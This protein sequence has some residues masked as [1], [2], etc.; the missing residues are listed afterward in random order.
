MLGK[1]EAIAHGDDKSR[2]R[3]SV[4]SPSN[5]QT[6]VVEAARRILLKYVATATAILAL[7][8]VAGVAGTYFL[9]MT[10]VNALIIGRLH[11]HDETIKNSFDASIR[12]IELLHETALKTYAE[13][14]RQSTLLVANNSAKADEIGRQITDIENRRAAAQSRLEQLK[15]DLDKFEKL[16]GTLDGGIDRIASNK[17]LRQAVAKSV[18]EKVGN[19]VTQL[20]ELRHIESDFVRISHIKEE[21]G[22]I[23]TFV[24]GDQPFEKQINFQSPYSAPPQIV[25][26]VTQS[27]LGGAYHTP[28]PNQTTTDENLM[29]LRPKIAHELGVKDVT[30]EGFTIISKPF[31]GSER[32]T[33][34]VNWVAFPRPAV[35]K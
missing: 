7:L 21:A 15:G 1:G 22:G 14:V 3:A 23:T 24:K 5:Y 25:L 28:L 16:A 32:Y 11:D 34:M 20:Q 18:A 31:D 26:S 13:S 27:N 12:S 2:G 30:T 10:S 9:L 35:R 4:G 19:D 33:L 8:V 29:R 6:L 17:E